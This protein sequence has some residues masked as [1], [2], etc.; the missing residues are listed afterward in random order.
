M[1]ILWNWDDTFQPPGHDRFSLRR[2]AVAAFEHVEFYVVGP[3]AQTLGKAFGH[4]RFVELILTARDVQQGRG[5]LLVGAIL[6]VAR[7][8]A[9]DADHAPDLA[10]M[11][12][13]KAIVH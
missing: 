13:G 9:A 7:H 5:H 10:G 4:F 12:S 11:G 3:H 1:E 2:E 6:P 8:S